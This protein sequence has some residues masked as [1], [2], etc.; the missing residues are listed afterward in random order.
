VREAAH[1]PRVAEDFALGNAHPGL[2]RLVIVTGGELH[3]VGGHH[4]Q[5]QPRRQL[6][7]PGHMHRVVGA[8][9]ALQFEVEPVRKDRGQ[10]QRQVRGPHRIALHERLAH[11]AALRTRQQDQPF[12]QLL[13]PLQLGPRPVP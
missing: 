10:L 4:R 5:V 11:R 8:A 13:Q 6:H 12:G 1:A 9:G 7:R 3:R 2:V